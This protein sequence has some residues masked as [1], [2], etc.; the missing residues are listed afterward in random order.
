M[1]EMTQGS[2]AQPA[3]WPTFFNTTALEAE[4]GGVRSHLRLQSE[5]KDI[6]GYTENLCL[7]DLNRPRATA[8]TELN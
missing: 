2:E 6:Q 1:W 7:K 3:W 5:F 4:A 8:A